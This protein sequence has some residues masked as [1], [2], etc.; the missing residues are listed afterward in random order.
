LQHFLRGLAVDRQQ[1]KTQAGQI[2]I[3]LFYA[4]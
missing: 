3:R 1:L 4:V 2:V